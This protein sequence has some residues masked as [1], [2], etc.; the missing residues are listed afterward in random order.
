MNCHGIRTLNINMI[1]MVIILTKKNIHTK[2]QRLFI[3]AMQ[4]LYIHALHFS[5]LS[6]FS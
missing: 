6:Q 3:S 5:P 4:I 1:A 2:T